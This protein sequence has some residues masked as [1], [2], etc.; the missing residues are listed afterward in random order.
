MTTIADRECKHPTSDD[1]SY[2]TDNGRVWTCS[3]CGD[4]RKWGRTW[5]YYGKAECVDCGFP[6]MTFVYCS[7]ECRK[8]YL[9]KH[10]GDEK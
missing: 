10:P 3:N 2:M 9:E 4:R 7:E 6:E 5:G 8:E 1:H